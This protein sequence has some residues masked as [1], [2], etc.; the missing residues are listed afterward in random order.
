MNEMLVALEICVAA[1]RRIK[2]LLIYSLLVNKMILTIVFSCFNL[3]NI[4][5][6]YI[7]KIKVCGLYLAK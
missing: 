4:S 2:R 3:V 7:S 1:K 5:I 6:E